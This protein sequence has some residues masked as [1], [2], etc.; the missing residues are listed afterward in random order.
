MYSSFVDIVYGSR[1][2][3]RKCAGCG[4]SKETGIITGREHTYIFKCQ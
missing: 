3:Y 2:K 4:I 1:E